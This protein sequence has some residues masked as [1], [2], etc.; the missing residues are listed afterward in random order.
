MISSFKARTVSVVF[1]RGAC[2]TTGEKAKELGITKALCFHGKS[3]QK[4]GIANKIINSLQE[5]GIDVLDSDVSMSDTPDT[6]VNETAA[7]AKEAGVN[8]IVAVG[9]GSALDAAKA[10]NVLMGNEPPINKYFGSFPTKP[11]VPLILIPTT[12]GTGSEV[13]SVAV[14]TNTANNTKNGVVGAATTANL[15]IV[16]PELTLGMPPELT[17]VSGIDAFSHAVEAYTSLRMNP[18]SDILAEKTIA[19][20]LKNLPLAIADG[21]NLTV[22]TNMSFAALLGGTAFSD[23]TVHLGHSIAHTLGAAYHLAHGIGCAV[24]LP[25]V[26][27][28]VATAVPEKVIGL[29]KL[30]GLTDLEKLST[31]DLGKKVADSIR[32]F[33]RK[34]GIPSLTS[35]EIDESSLAD[36]VPTVLADKCTTNT[37]IRPTEEQVLSLLKSAYQY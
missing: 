36:L 23:A 28:F 32:E 2:L 15:A 37:V 16:D 20:I 31:A 34:V 24:A 12:S 21:S 7:M 27:E 9:G 14:V 11:G 19:L 13:T 22:R 35:F 29:G 8:G 5:A 3:V 33:C 26:V 30:M 25:P 6:I 17:A 4:A 1:G 10:I 18:M